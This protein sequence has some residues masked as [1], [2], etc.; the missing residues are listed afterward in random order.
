MFVCL[1]GIYCVRYE[2]MLCVFV[3]ERLHEAGGHTVYVEV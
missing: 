3:R 1:C 2:L